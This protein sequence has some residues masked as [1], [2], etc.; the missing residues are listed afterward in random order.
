MKTLQ[1]KALFFINYKF[2]ICIIN[3]QDYDEFTFYT[4]KRMNPEFNHPMPPYCLYDKNTGQ[5]VVS[6]TNKQQLFENYNNFSEQYSII[7]D[8]SWYKHFV[9]RYQIL[10]RK[11]LENE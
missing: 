9:E 3:V 8:L 6:A 5:V 1:F 7:R 2:K 10:K 4:T 11:E